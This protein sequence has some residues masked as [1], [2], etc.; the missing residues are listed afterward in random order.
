M[1]FERFRVQSAIELDIGC[2]DLTKWNSYLHKFKEYEVTESKCE[3][4]LS[5]LKKDSA[6]IYF[7][8]IFSLADAISGLYNGRH[9]W[10]VIKIYYSVFFLLRCSLA[11]NKYAFLK[12]KGIY[13]LKLSKGELPE[14]RD[15]GK[16][17]GERISGDHKTTIVTYISFFK[18][19]DILQTNTVDGKNIYEWL[20]ELRN[21]VNYRE[22][23]FTEPSNKYFF[24]TL[25]DKEKIKNQIEVYLKDDSYVYCFDEE[26]CNLA[27]PLKL[28]LIVRKQLYD[29]IDFEPIAKNKIM[30]IDKLLS[31]SGLNRSET[32][33]SL[34]DFGR[35]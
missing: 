13:T 3:N 33:K 17:A 25:F 34:Y 1:S 6:D 5:E 18:D 21:Q 22:R 30:E 26:H 16:Y 28:A 32:F 2:T 8:A 7:K 19:T 23:E 12:N 11:T 4:L 9:S 24:R 14:R 29:F 15:S 10:S 35:S 27:A 31:G 20:M